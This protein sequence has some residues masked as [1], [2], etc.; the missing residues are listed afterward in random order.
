ML[1]REDKD[2]TDF[3][4]GSRYTFSMKGGDGMSVY[5]DLVIVI[6]FLVDLLLLLG[7]NRLTGYPPGIL[8]CAVSSAVGGLYAGICMLPG[9]SFLGNTLWRTVFLCVM[10][11]LAFGW[12]GSALRR[13]VLFVFLSMAMGGIALG[14]GKNS[15]FSLI[16]TA[17]VVVGMCVLAFRGKL[18]GQKFVP[19]ELTLGG[20]KYRL[21]ALL[22]T[23]N[24]LKDPVT[25]QQVL[26]VGADVAQ[27]VLGLSSMELSDPIGTIGAG[28]VPGL[29]LI[30]Y[31]AVG[32]SGGMLLCIRFDEVRINGEQGGKL[33]AFAPDKI[34]GDG[35]YQALTGGIL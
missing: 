32:Q 31:R 33:V 18:N 6:N 12:N 9:F 34:G 23:G 19:V 16:M 27:R 26:V 4:M 3:F 5:L 10:A 1:T 17:L 13:G 22:D 25:G 15:L 30:P 2:A 21:I 11:V 7:T 35:S 14:I 8:R 28:S 20:H 29:R 24:T